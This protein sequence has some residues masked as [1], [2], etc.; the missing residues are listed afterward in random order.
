MKQTLEDLKLKY[1][2]QIV[3]NCDN[4]SFINISRNL[5]MHSKTKHIPIQYHYLREHVSLKTIKLE[6]VDSK[7]QIVDIFTKPLSKE[8]FEYLIQKF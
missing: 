7:E 1:D 3:R 6:Y 4:T 5:V 2:H 8:I